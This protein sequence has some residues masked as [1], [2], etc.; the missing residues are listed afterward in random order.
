MG[1]FNGYRRGG[2]RCGS[3]GASASHLRDDFAEF[4]ALPA[5]SCFVRS[6]SQPTRCGKL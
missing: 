4:D 2:A 6:L 3:V 5:T 1:E